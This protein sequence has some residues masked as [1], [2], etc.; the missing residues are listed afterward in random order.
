MRLNASAKL[1][2]LLSI[3]FIP[4]GSE[5]DTNPLFWLADGLAA[6]GHA[7]K[8]LLSP[9]YVRLADKRSL[10]WEP[11]GTAEEFE[12]LIRNP[13]LWDRRKG[14]ETV[15]RG[16]LA[17]LDDFRRAFE[18]AGGHY[19]LAVTSSF[20]LAGSTL[21]EAA[22]IPRLTLHMQPVCLRSVYELPLFMEELRFL[23]RS[24]RWLKRLF[25][26]LVDVSF[27]RKARRPFNAFRRQLGLS[28][29]RHFYEE[30]VNGA[31]GVAAMFPEWFASPQPDWPVNVRQF[32]F[33]LSFERKDLPLDLNTFLSAGE[34]PIVWTHGSAN[35]DI[36]HFQARAI[37]ISRELGA[38]C[39]LISLDPPAGPLPTGAFH[40]AHVRFEDLFP[41][42]LAAVH[43]GGIGTTSKCI[44]A[45]IPQ[46]IVPRSHD[47]PDNADRIVRLGL[48]L[49]C[50]Y[51]KLDSSRA[52]Q[53]LRHLVGTPSFKIR[54][55]EFSAR[56]RTEK[57]LGELCDW[58][59]QIARQPAALPTPA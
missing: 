48:G 41:R 33:P 24:P 55:A 8:F 10:P 5:G 54:C 27:W 34:P 4:F 35:F 56:L 21:A 38:R 42:C 1:K 3:L 45:G 49:T 2:D 9:H 17:T 46:L 26:R 22:G 11:I 23:Q 36:V 57:F 12:Q 19:D 47:Q 14:P 25:F 59:E 29:F 30:A 53:T 52:A 6:R 16:M 13:Q 20:A 44:A 18:K 43:H 32:G 7:V 50:A 15:M 28:P 40:A 51:S 37:E 39:L 31:Q 58:S